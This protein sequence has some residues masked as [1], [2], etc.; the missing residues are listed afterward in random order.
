MKHDWIHFQTKVEYLKTNTLNRFL[1]NAKVN[2][3]S[4]SFELSVNAIA[5]LN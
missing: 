2:F 4:A 5:V 1:F 3:T